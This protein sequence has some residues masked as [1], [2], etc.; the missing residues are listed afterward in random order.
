MKQWQIQKYQDDSE[1]PESQPY[2]YELQ[3]RLR[4]FEELLQ[5]KSRP[6]SEDDDYNQLEKARDFENYEYKL[7]GRSEQ[8]LEDVRP[9]A[10]NDFSFGE[11]EVAEPVVGRLVEKS[12]LDQARMADPNE[13]AY[14]P[15]DLRFFQTTQ[16]DKNGESFGF[17]VRDLYLF[18]FF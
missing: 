9:Y 6:S 14:P 11:E 15:S 17:C 8:I 13:F 2:D 18:W 7:P 1:E 12:P 10:E 16:S 4:Q 3:E 5:S